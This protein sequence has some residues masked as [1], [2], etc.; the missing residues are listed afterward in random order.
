MTENTRI[1]FCYQISTLSF[2]DHIRSPLCFWFYA[3]GILLKSY[4]SLILPKSCKSE[5]LWIL[6]SRSALEFALEK[7]PHL[8]HWVTE[9][10]VLSS[11]SNLLWP[12]A[13]QFAQ[14]Y[15]N[16]ILYRGG[17]IYFRFHLLE[18]GCGRASL[19]L[20]FHK[21][22]SFRN[23]LFLCNADNYCYIFRLTAF[24]FYNVHKDGVPVFVK[25]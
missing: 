5:A 25:Q 3:G 16:I 8:R 19:L 1:I 12:V 2:I 17:S 15:E 22:E 14:L 9:A 11:Q 23:F 18:F 21:S 7:R 4:L 6:P 20:E 13:E 10:A 24:Q